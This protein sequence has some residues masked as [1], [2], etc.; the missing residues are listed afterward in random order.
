VHVGLNLVF[1]VPG[2]MSG[3]ETYARELIPALLAERPDIRVTAFIN[4]EAAE[5]GDGPWRDLAP[6]VMV[7][8]RARRRT[9]WVF[10]EQ[11][12]LPVLAQR[13]GVNLLHSLINTGPAWGRFRRVL[14]I[15]DV[16][17]RIYPE[18]H[19]P[20][21]TLALRLLVPLSA[22]TADRIIVPSEATKEDVTRLL[23][24]DA[25]KVDLVPHGVGITHVDRA[26]PED[27]LRGRYDLGSRPIVFTLSL[28]RKHKNLERL[29]DA[30]ALIPTQRR[31]VLVLAGHATPYEQELRAHAAET[32]VAADARFLGWLSPEELEGLYRASTCFVFP[33]LYE[34]FG[35]PVLEAMARGVPVA[36]SDRGSLAEIVDDAALTFNPEEP[37]AIAAA[38]E[39]LLTDPTERKRLSAKGRANAARFTWAE[40]ARRTLEV[41]ERT[42]GIRA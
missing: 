30:L 37:R 40:T 3:P 12:L 39:K 7:P 19:S 11:Q 17:Y 6:A 42:L 32:G 35:L 8:V 24:I 31:P 15:Q 33:S 18:A 20:L 2:E 27:V 21:R 10:G 1:L 16:I 34:G 14:T 36:C 23:R 22:R 25:S 28:K 5:E 41:Y 29:L 38:I 13:A 26:E 4:R 9:S